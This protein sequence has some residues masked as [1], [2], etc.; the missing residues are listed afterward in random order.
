MEKGERIAKVRKYLGLNQAQLARQYGI[1]QVALSNIES[2]KAVVKDYYLDFL[3]EHY[4]I[5]KAW[6]HTGVGNMLLSNDLYSLVDKAIEENGEMLQIL[7]LL[8]KIQ[9][10]QS[11]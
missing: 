10:K 3:S 4:G 2:G 1:T 9:N 11:Q 8:Q 7:N 5:N 6:L